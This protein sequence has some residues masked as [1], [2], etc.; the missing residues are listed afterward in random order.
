MSLEFDFF[1]FS[2]SLFLE[3]TIS[4]YC[5]FKYQVYYFSRN[6]RL[7]TLDLFQI[8][9]SALFSTS[10]AP[11]IIVLCSVRHL[12]HIRFQTLEKIAI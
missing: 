6:T 10:V 9:K 12:I 3:Q 8:E 5:K 11:A 4:F 2:L 7:S 1:E